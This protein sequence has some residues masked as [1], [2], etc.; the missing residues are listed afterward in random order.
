ML[1]LLLV[2]IETSRRIKKCEELE[3]GNGKNISQIGQFSSSS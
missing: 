2:N 3:T 1:Y